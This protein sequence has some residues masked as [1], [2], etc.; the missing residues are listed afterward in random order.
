MNSERVTIWK[1]HNDLMI[2]ISI[3]LAMNI[4][5]SCSKEEY[6]CN[7]YEIY[8]MDVDSMLIANE[9]YF[10]GSNKL[11]SLVFIFENGFKNDK[12]VTKIYGRG[13]NL[14]YHKEAIYTS[15]SALGIADYFVLKFLP[16]FW[17]LSIQI[18]DSCIY[19]ATLKKEYNNIVVGYKLNNDED[20]RKFKRIF[21]IRMSNSGVT[22]Q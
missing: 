1:N 10:T 3:I 19:S 8:Y 15:S 7:G 14:L 2:F 6:N 12:V 5:C 9:E 13:E 11:D 17:K 4:L 20:I 16:E 22:Y 21:Q 18:N